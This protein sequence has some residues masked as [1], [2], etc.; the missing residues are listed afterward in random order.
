MAS[1]FPAAPRPGSDLAL[2]STLGQRWQ[3]HFQALTALSVLSHFSRSRVVW[4]WNSNLLPIPL[5]PLPA[6]PHPL[7]CTSGNTLFFSSPGCAEQH[8]ENLIAHP[9]R[10]TE[11]VGWRLR[12][13]AV[14]EGTGLGPGLAGRAQAWMRGKWGERRVAGPE[15]PAL[16]PAL[17]LTGSG[18]FACH[19][20]S[21]PQLPHL[22]RRWAGLCELGTS[23]TR[24][25]SIFFPNP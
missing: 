4:P 14:R 17:F 2:S 20:C 18:T 12:P 21:R 5:P 8:I 13:A 9:P 22:Q 10:E 1:F 23:S 6:L 15:R 25:E 19:F 7:A 3:L 16:T 24:G 11:C